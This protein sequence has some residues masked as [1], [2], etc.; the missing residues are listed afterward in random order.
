MISAS[1]LDI[2]L[3]SELTVADS[4]FWLFHALLSMECQE[5]GEY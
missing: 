2:D 1:L 4:A 3:I 5:L